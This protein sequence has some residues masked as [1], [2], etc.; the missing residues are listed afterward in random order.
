MHLPQSKRVGEAYSGSKSLDQG[1]RKKE[2]EGER[3]RKKI[4]EKEN[5]H[6]FLLGLWLE[7]MSHKLCSRMAGVP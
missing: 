4:K 7:S 5:Q 2:R 6:H 1:R 3:E